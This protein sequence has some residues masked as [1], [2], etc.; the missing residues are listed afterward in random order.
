MVWCAYLI[1]IRIHIAFG[2][3]SG[4]SVGFHVIVVEGA[5]ESQ[6]VIFG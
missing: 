6:Y 5:A 4:N 3:E 1:Y 2:D